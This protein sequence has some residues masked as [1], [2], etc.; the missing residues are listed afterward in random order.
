LR[1]LVGEIL[2]AAKFNGES[3]LV[4]TLESPVAYTFILWVEGILIHPINCLSFDV[5]FAYTV[6]KLI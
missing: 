1:E 4:K 6:L 2:F 3:V 5:I